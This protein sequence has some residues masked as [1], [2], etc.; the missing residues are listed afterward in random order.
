MSLSLIQSLRQAQQEISIV[1]PDVGHLPSHTGEGLAIAEIVGG[2]VLGRFP[3]ALPVPVRFRQI[4]DE[5]PVPVYAITP[6]K[7]KILSHAEC[8]L[9]DHGRHHSGTYGDV[10]PVLN[11][12]DTPRKEKKVPFGSTTDRCPLVH[13]MSVD[14]IVPEHRMSGAWYSQPEGIG[15]DA[16]CLERV[17][18]SQGT[19]LEVERMNGLQEICRSRHF[20]P[21]IPGRVSNQFFEP[22]SIRYRQFLSLNE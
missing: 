5:Y 16:E 6:L 10:H 15:L 8:L 1:C 14:D 2:V 20:F 17:V 18:Y 12:T 22:R 13:R 3:I 9:E 4:H 19:G 21:V 7:R 11:I